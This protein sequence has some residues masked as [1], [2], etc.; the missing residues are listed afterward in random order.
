MVIVL[1]KG[2]IQKEITVHPTLT[3]TLILLMNSQDPLEC[4]SEPGR[5]KTG[6]H[7]IQDTRHYEVG[8]KLWIENNAKI[9]T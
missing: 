5:Y 4:W 6:I 1:T 9:K 7:S 8:K 3:I 2:K